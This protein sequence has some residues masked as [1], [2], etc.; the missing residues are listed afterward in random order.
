MGIVAHAAAVARTDLNGRAIFPAVPRG[1]YYLVGTF[2]P[3]IQPVVW[4][5]KVTLTSGASQLTIDQRNA[6]VLN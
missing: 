3:T 5:V 4:D 6:A 2:G 1:D